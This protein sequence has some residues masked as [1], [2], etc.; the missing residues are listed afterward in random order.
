MSNLKVSVI[1]P[2]RN[3]PEILRRCLE[4]IVQ[5]HSY[6]AYDEFIVVDN[7]DN[8][9][10]IRLNRQIVEDMGI[11]YCEEA[12]S[13]LAFARNT[14]IRASAGDI[15][16]FADDDFVVHR[17]WIRNLVLGYGDNEVMCCTGRIL[18]YRQDRA[19]NVFARTMGYDKGDRRH[20]FTTADINLLKLLKTVTSIGKMRL[21]DKT[22]VP[23]AVGAG[24]CSFRKRVFNDLGY[25]DEELRVGTVSAGEDMDMFYRILKAGHKIVYQPQAVVNHDDPQTIEGVINKSY[26]YG[27]HRQALFTK[28]RKD[29]Y[30]LS[31][32][33]GFFLFSFFAWLRTLLKLEWEERKVITAGVKGFLNGSSRSW[34]RNIAGGKR[35]G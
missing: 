6:Y 5:S 31:L 35:H 8:R 17:D 1:V 33:L 14:G 2:T 4:S 10:K 19:S 22:P 11:R 16:V 23:W 24:F 3:R 32:C 20:I 34:L 26:T 30:M 29:P 12:R 21:G 27:L 7:S 18:P 25:F 15:I 13:G 9:A 28:Y